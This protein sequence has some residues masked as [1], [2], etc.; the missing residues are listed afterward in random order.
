[1]HDFYLTY[2]IDHHTIMRHLIIPC[3]MVLKSNL[4]VHI[5]QISRHIS[6][7]LHKSIDLLYFPL[8]H[9]N[10]T[11]PRSYVCKDIPHD[12][13][14]FFH[15]VLPGR[16]PMNDRAQSNK[17]IRTVL[18]HILLCKLYS[19]VIRMLLS[20]PVRSLNGKQEGWIPM[21]PGDLIHFDLLFDRQVPLRIVERI[22]FYGDSAFLFHF[23]LTRPRALV[24]L[25]QLC[26]H[27]PEPPCIAVRPLHRLFCNIV[28]S[29]NTAPC[30]RSFRTILTEDEN[31][32]HG[33]RT[34]A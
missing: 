11:A 29:A 22:Q 27:D 1:M 9:G 28:Y 25:R 3:L 31:H 15:P 30:A 13:C 12:R 7:Y 20:I 5:S 6:L 8:Y 18:C 34:A 33:N 32:L 21:R 16:D 19:P 23:D 24:A 14:C 26:L 10:I 2:I 17:P 4:P